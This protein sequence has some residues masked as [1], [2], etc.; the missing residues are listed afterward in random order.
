MGR[1][2]FRIARIE[3]AEFKVGDGVVADAVQGGDETTVFLTEDFGEFYADQMHL[4]EHA[5]RE[6]IGVGVK[7]VEDGALVGL[8]HRFQLEYV[9]DEKHL[10]ATKW[11][12]HFL[13]KHP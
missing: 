12:S 9:A 13:T 11:F 2:R 3:Q 5:G 1:W 10:L 4:A 6:E 8:Y 7:A